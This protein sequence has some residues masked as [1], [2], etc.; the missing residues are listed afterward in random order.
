MMNQIGSR[1]A[2]T[3]SSPVLDEPRLPVSDLDH[4][5]LENDVL[6][7]VG[8]AGLDAQEMPLIPALEIGLRPFTPRA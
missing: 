8:E 6:K 4:L 5:D 3:L 2:C 7:N 1:V